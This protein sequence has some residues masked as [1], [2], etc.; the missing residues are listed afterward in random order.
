MSEAQD[1]GFLL[2]DTLTREKRKVYAEDG[3]TLRFYCCGPTVYGPAHVGNFRTFVVQDLFRRV[4]EGAGLATRHVRNLTDVDDKTIRDSQAAGE[5]LKAF[6]DHWR[7]RFHE[8]C[9]SL[10]L[11]APHEE[12]SAAAHVKQ[13]VELIESLMEKGHA[14]V[15]ED[16]SAYF[17]ISSF[18]EYGRL[19]RL[20]ER[21]LV[22]G[23]GG[24]TT[25]DDE[26]SKETVGD[27]ALWKARRPED[28]DNFW[29]SPWGEGRPG[30]HLECSAMCREYLGDS[31]D[32]HS[33]GE[34]LVFPHHENEIAQSECATGKTFARH[35][36]HV[37]HLLVDGG[38]MSKSLGNFHTLSDLAEKGYGTELVRYVLL[39]GHYGQSLNF[40]FASL[41]AANSALGKLVK[42]HESLGGGAPPSYE[43][44][45]ARGSEDL[46][47]FAPAWEALLDDL[48]APKAL[49]AL[50]SALK[51]LGTGRT[52]DA[53]RELTRSAFWFVL[54]VLGILLP[55][56]PQAA[57]VPE[58]VRD[59]AE[60][61]LAAKQAKDWGTAD[62]LREEIASAGWQVKDRPD[63]YDLEPK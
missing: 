18:P 3:E 17:R 57:E 24:R 16:G 43:E 59:L 53:E 35:W 15:G 54:N 48:N 26:Y 6:T 8:D 60:R 38:K 62:A 22:R 1:T 13:Q 36:F 10:N 23:A 56:K 45:L 4:A 32:L 9:S 46:G 47:P 30:W 20:K 34:D 41:D 55:E 29:P 11:L 61:R 25:A 28:G 33:G 37:S 27:F 58:E 40:T 44:S 52:D 63:G 49:G 21:E 51:E 42:A 50:F 7:D 39:S 5:T 19:S 14:Y 31:F 2:K 12:P